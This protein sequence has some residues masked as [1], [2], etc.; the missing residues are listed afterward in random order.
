MI[1]IVRPLWTDDLE[2]I[3]RIEEASYPF[4][5]TGGIF[6]DCIRAGYACYGLQLEQQLVGYSISNWAAGESHLLN[7][8]IDP[9][10]RRRGFG[11]MLLEHTVNRARSLD[12]HVMFLEVRPSNADAAKLY[13]NLGFSEVGKRPAYY[14]SQGG[15]EDAVVMRLDLAVHAGK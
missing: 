13:R 14:Q 6:R 9:A 8:C 5:W 11:R 1:P 15:R 10:W 7:L 12:C 2:E 4:P 3:M